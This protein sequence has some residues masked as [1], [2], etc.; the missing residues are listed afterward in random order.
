MKIVK[1]IYF[2]YRNVSADYA[3]ALRIPRVV[4]ENGKIKEVVRYGLI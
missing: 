3:V 2:W 1:S 4:I